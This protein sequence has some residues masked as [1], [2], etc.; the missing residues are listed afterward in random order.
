VFLESSNTGDTFILCQPFPFILENIVIL[1][2][3]MYADQEM[4]MQLVTLPNAAKPAKQSPD[5]LM[6]APNTGSL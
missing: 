4:T 6:Y 3:K 1:N 2:N 5:I